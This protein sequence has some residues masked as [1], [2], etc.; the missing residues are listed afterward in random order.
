[1][2]AFKFHKKKTQKK[3]KIVPLNKELASHRPSL[4]DI[5]ENCKKLVRASE[6]DGR[7]GILGNSRSPANLFGKTLSFLEWRE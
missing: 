6:L 4:N 5:L 3:K 7:S 2:K 1:M